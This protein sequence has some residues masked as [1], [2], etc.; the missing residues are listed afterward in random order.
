MTFGYFSV[1]DEII[2]DVVGLTIVFV[3]KTTGLFENLN[4]SNF[5]IILVSKS[6]QEISFPR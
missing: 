6:S 2:L 1:K 5:S 3:I 4:E